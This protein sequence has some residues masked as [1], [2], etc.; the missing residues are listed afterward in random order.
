MYLMRYGYMDHLESQEVAGRSANLLSP[1]AMKN[2]I[3]EFQRFAGLNVTGEMD[4]E[5]ER[6]MAQPR[7]G[8]KDI[9]G[10]GARAKRFALQGELLIASFM[11]THTNTCTHMMVMPVLLAC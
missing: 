7:C 3:M 10:H 4:E 6:M 11:C 2:S 5:T 1:D 9:V 8:V